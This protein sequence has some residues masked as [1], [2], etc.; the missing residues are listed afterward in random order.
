MRLESSE[1]PV[2]EQTVQV[3][4]PQG[5]GL[6]FVEEGNPGCQLSVLDSDGALKNYLGQLSPD[7][8]TLTFSKVNL[9]PTGK[10]STATA[11]VAVKAADPSTTGRTSLTFQMGSQ[12]SQSTPIEVGAR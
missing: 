12:T 5:M 6:Q 11:S 10:S 1:G 8:R 3:S 2:P 9:A 4:Q 7:G